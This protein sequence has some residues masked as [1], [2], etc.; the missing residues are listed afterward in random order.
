[1]LK[2]KVTILLIGL[3]CFSS[4]SG[5]FKVTCHG[6]DG[7]V[8]VEPVFHNHCECP[9][10]DHT[11]NRNNSS[12]SDVDLSFEH[13]HCKDIMTTSDFYV[14]AQK[15]HTTS[16]LKIVTTNSFLKSVSFDISLHLRYSNTKHDKL[17]P[18]FTPLRTVILLAWNSF[19]TLSSNCANIVPKI[20]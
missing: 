9:E 6:S 20:V 14:L 5:F 11:D 4:V 3:M 12:E 8:A 7:H 13:N 19:S 18:F 17:S 16:L 1:M 2:Q 10:P 15:N